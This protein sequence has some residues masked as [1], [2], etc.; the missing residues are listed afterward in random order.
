MVSQYILA[1]SLPIR[2]ISLSRRVTFP[3]QIFLRVLPFPL[4]SAHE[5]LKPT[6]KLS[7]L[8]GETFRASPCAV[9]S[10][11][12]FRKCSEEFVR[13]SIVLTDDIILRNS[14]TLQDPTENGCE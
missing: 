10:R 6:R 9:A 12:A 5:K 1:S 11:K 3:C 13:V 7:K 4:N 2:C 14:D 8:K